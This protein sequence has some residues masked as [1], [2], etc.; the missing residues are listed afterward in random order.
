MNDRIILFR[1]KPLILLQ[2]VSCE[3]YIFVGAK[4]TPLVCVPLGIFLQ[5]TNLLCF[6]GFVG[7]LVALADYGNVKPH[8][9]LQAVVDINMEERLLIRADGN[10]H[11]SHGI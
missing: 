3:R 4:L 10:A 1:K 11:S 8:R 5:E 9:V 2:L 7:A 6:S